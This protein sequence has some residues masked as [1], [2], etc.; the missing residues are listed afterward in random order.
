VFSSSNPRGQ[1]CN[2]ASIHPLWILVSRR[3]TQPIWPS[4]AQNGKWQ[5]VAWK[6]SS[7]PSAF[8]A[9][10]RQPKLLVTAVQQLEVRQV[11]SFLGQVSAVE[12]E[13]E[14]DSAVASAEVSSEEVA[15]VA[16]EEVVEVPEGP[17][18]RVASADRVG[19]SDYKLLRQFT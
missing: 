14:A 15:V 1:P 9:S 13:V 3:T 16:E 12:V 18:I 11:L 17:T 4:N 2:A 6:N 5:R 8:V 7:G 10:E 19:D